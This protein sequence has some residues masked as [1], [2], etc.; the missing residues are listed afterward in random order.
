VEW[1]AELLAARDRRLGGVTAPAQGL[2]FVTAYY[3]A[4][5][6]LPPPPVPPVFG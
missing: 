3:D 6:D 1:A 2:Y 5:A 4:N